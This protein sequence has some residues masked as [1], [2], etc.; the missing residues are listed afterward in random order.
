VC[1]ST[2]KH[3][4]SEWQVRIVSLEHEHGVFVALLLSSFQTVSMPLKEQIAIF[5]D[6]AGQNWQRRRDRWRDND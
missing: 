4:D 5:I 1:P 2:G 6:I 3:S